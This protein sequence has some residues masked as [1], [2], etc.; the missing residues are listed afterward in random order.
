MQGTTE[1]CQYN[2]EILPHKKKVHRVE[3]RR[4]YNLFQFPIKAFPKIRI[5]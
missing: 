3:G 2:N 4:A 5:R 1:K